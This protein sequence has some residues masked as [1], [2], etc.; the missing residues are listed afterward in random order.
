MITTCMIFGLEWWKLLI[1]VLFVLV[2]VSSGFVLDSSNSYFYKVREYKRM[3]IGDKYCRPY[4]SE[5]QLDRCQKGDRIYAI[6]T[7]KV[8]SDNK[9]DWEVTYDYYINDVLVYTNEKMKVFKTRLEFF[10]NWK[11]LD[12]YGC[13]LWLWAKNYKGGKWY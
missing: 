12:Y 5:K 13:L 11:R 8:E 9:R 3:K 6:V 2:G 1:L 7:D 4:Y 10:S